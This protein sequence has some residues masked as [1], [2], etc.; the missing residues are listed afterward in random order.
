MDEIP[1]VIVAERR[2]VANALA[3][4]P[5]DCHPRGYAIHAQE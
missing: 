1:G 5:R 2:R 3:T 4:R